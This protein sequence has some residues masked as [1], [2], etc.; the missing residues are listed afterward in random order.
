M[1]FHQ[2]DGLRGLSS[3]MIIVYHF[4]KA[5]S[6]DWFYN[7]FIVRQGQIFVDVFFVM[8]GFVIALNYQK[9]NSFNSYV[10][11]LKK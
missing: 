7:F 11:F 1:R 2:L 6:P 5:Y 10:E 9:I 4:E 8:S 3:L